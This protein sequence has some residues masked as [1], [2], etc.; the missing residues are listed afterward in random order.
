MVNDLLA[1]LTSIYTQLCV[2]FWKIEVGI[3]LDQMAFEGANN[4]KAWTTF[5]LVNSI[6]SIVFISVVASFFNLA[7]IGSKN[8][9][10]EDVNIFEKWYAA[11]YYILPLPS[12]HWPCFSWMQRME[13]LLHLYVA[14]E[15]KYFVFSSPHFNQIT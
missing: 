9:E 7:W 5:F 3:L 11:I 4:L 12:Y 13:L 14:L 15:W 1:P 6:R 8:C 2:G 10:Q